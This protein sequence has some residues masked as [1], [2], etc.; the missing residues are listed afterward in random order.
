M[1]IS[2]LQYRTTLDSMAEAIHVINADF[3]IILLNQ[4]FK[5]WLDSSGIDSK[6]VGKTVFEAFPFLP[7]R[8]A[9]EYRHVFATGLLL[10]SEETTTVHGKAVVTES[11][12]IP[13]REKGTV[14]Q[15]IT[16]IQ[17][18]TQRKQAAEEKRLLEARILQAQKIESLGV[19]SGGVA[20]D[21]NNVLQ[22][23]LGFNEKAGRLLP[24][25]S[26]AQACL[27]E[28]GRAATLASDICRK[29]LAYAGSGTFQFRPVSLSEALSNIR[30]MLGVSIPRK[31]RLRFECAADLPLLNADSTQLSQVIMNLVIN[32]S[33]ALSDHEGEI[34]VTTFPETVSLGN[35]EQDYWGGII[36]PGR[37]V[38]LEVADTGPGMPPEV[39]SRIF[40]PFFSTKFSGRGLGLTAVRGIVKGHSGFIQV[41]SVFGQGTVFRLFF[42]Q[43]DE[44]LAPVE[45]IS[46][47]GDWRGTGTILIVDDEKAILT[48]LAE[49]L[50]TLGFR[51]IMA[52]D[53]VEA[54]GLFRANP[55]AITGVLLDLTMPNMD[56]RETLQEFRK[57]RSD[58]KIILTSGF[59]ETEARG[60]F[61]NQRPD[62]F[63]QK[64]YQFSDLH[65]VLARVFG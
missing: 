20:H 40:D 29:L 58:L 13:V 14:I 43:P 61:S 39:H 31:V 54:L 16:V 33:E 35:Q 59:S 12:K 50:E 64:P 57:V 42:P 53:G 6:I 10:I 3:R 5:N 26:P 17:D 27:Q 55:E 11:R 47:V 48:L 52:S 45:R 37:Y 60:L 28:I 25:E 36:P 56:G 4:T 21:F 49:L 44:P 7:T 38:V 30:E 46:Q 63:L 8:V 32:G 1:S 65:A 23:I 18:V 2:D 34:T 24:A 9:E 41:L 22:I 19:L 15:I 62:A 51:T